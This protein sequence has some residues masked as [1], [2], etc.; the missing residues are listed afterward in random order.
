MSLH[1]IDFRLNTPV[2]YAAKNGMQEEAD[3]LIL[4]AP[5]MN[6]M[7]YAAKIKES[8]FK[9]YKQIMGD[10]S[11]KDLMKKSESMPEEDKKR[12]RESTEY[13]GSG[14]EVLFMMGADC[15]AIFDD[16]KHIF[17]NGGCY[18]SDEIRM[19]DNILSSLSYEDF[20][21]MAGEYINV[22]FT[23]SSANQIPQVS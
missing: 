4:R 6:N 9:A 1:S 22:F 11:V 21:R 2:K 15:A 18:I 20:E 8:V 5:T 3:T 13:Q 10:P 7:R 14:L 12:V 19:T 23:S 16:I 17:L